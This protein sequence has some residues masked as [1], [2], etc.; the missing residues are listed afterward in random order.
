ML[1][2]GGSAAAYYSYYVPKQTNQKVL[3]A[4]SNLLSEKTSDGFSLEANISS[5]DAS[6]PEIGIKLDNSVDSERNTRTDISIIYSA[7]N[8][9]GSIIT[10][11]SDQTAYLKINDLSTLLS[12][13]DSFVGGALSGL[14]EAIGDKWIKF[15]AN[16]LTS[17]LAGQGVNSDSANK[18]T[19][20]LQ[21]L[22]GSNQQNLIDQLAAAY[23]ANAFMK[24]KKVGSETINSSKATKYQLTIDKNKFIDFILSENIDLSNLESACGFSLKQAVENKESIKSQADAL[25]ITDTYI[26]L[27]NDKVVRIASKLTAEGTTLSVE[28]TLTGKALDSSKPEDT[29]ELNELIDEYKNQ[30]LGDYLNQLNSSYPGG[31]IPVDLLQS[32]EDI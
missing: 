31:E 10:R 18:C 21:N 24:A 17:E 29:V 19:T 26:W 30:L 27:T 22:M 3:S 16:T 11:A 5:G 23:D 13:A 12:L 15:D 7:F 8:L 25:S 4:I 32:I 9:S 14:K 2:I 6:V 1:F 28:A 20:A